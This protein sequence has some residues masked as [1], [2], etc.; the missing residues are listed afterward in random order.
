MIAD[1]PKEHA[2]VAKPPQGEGKRGQRR[3]VDFAELY[4]RKQAR[5]QTP[6]VFITGE[7]EIRATVVEY[8]TFR[9]V[10]RVDGEPTPVDVEKISLHYH[11]KQID[12]GIVAEKI[13]V[14]EAVR[15][16]NE[17][18]P[19][20]YQDRHHL[21]TSAFWRAKRRDIDVRFTMRD[22]SV[23]CGSVEWFTHYE[24]KLN[25]GMRDEEDAASVIL[26][27]HAMVQLELLEKETTVATSNGDTA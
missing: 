6:M 11:Y 20:A 18:T 21:P 17:P 8:G 7:G 12:A 9:H 24:V 2:K 13:A 5:Q 19:L 4:M 14:D 15:A 25:V 3:R 16:K 27:R 1:N 10:L 23:F 22:G 26:H